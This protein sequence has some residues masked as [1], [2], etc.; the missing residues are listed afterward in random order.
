MSLV[1][2]RGAHLV[3][4]PGARLA[5]LRAAQ[6]LWFAQACG[7]F[8]LLLITLVLM[9]IDDRLFQGVSLWKKPAKFALSLAVLFGTW[10]WFAG[11]L[12]AAWWRT[13]PARVLAWLAVVTGAFEMVY[14]FV[15]AGLGQAS[16]F[17]L[18]TPFTSVM[19]SLM[20]VGATLLVSVCLWLAIALVRQVPGWR[21]EPFLLSVVLGLLVTFVLGGGFGG[22]LGSHLSHW[23]AATPTDAG[24]LP[25]F[26]WARDGG[27]LRVAHFFGMHAMQVIPAVGLLARDRLPRGGTVAVVVASLAWSGL[28][29]FT[30]VQALR[31]LPFA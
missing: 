12:P 5:R 24:G 14:I 29:V 26:D 2:P 11:L 16:H 19:Y 20:G 23:V 21:R 18:A 13:T 3:G 17:N 4:S 22:Y 28:C 27:D 31:G 6:P 15:M 8:A 1:L 25:G 9:L 10:T 7:Y 30:F